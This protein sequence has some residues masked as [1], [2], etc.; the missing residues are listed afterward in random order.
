MVNSALKIKNALHKMIKAHPDHNQKTVA[1]HVGVCHSH[2]N[3]TLSG[4]SGKELE[5]LCKMAEC[6]DVEIVLRRKG[7]VPEPKAPEDVKELIKSY[8]RQIQR[9]EAEIDSLKRRASNA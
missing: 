6:V 1:A 2:V 9:L 7:E 3:Q 8:E 4:K 5:M